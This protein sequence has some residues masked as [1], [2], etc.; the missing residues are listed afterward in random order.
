MHSI[1]WP[2]LK[3][4]SSSDTSDCGCLLVEGNLNHL[5]LEVCVKVEAGVC[6][7]LGSGRNKSTTWRG[8]ERGRRVWTVRAHAVVRLLIFFPSVSH[9]LAPTLLPS[10]PFLREPQ[11]HDHTFPLTCFEKV[12]C[13][14]LQARKT[15]CALCLAASSD[16]SRQPF[17]TKTVIFSLSFLCWLNLFLLQ[18]ST[19]LTVRRKTHISDSRRLCPR[20]N[21][22]Y[23]AV[24]TVW[25]IQWLLNEND[26]SNVILWQVSGENLIT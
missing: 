3:G 20:Q 11:L 16:P 18:F 17:T 24:G 8:A 1:W 26:M 7:Y 15:V 21:H 10:L 25:N 19:F 4:S 9:S 6:A 22:I 5:I 23:Y 12:L 13:F 14:E 2:W